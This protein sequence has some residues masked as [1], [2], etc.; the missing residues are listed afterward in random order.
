MIDTQAL[1]RVH[2][3][4]SDGDEIELG[5]V[6]RRQPVVLAMVRQFG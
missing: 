2:V 1:A 6:W 5:S 4:S 3:L